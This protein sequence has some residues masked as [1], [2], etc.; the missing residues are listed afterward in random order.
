M[1]WLSAE[2]LLAVLGVLATVGVLAY[3]RLIPG[4]KRIGYRVQ[5]D[6]P[7]GGDAHNGQPDVRLGLFGEAPEMSDASL[8][9]LRIE[10][11]GLRGISADDYTWRELT[12]LTV[13]FTERTVT[14]VAVTEPSHSHLIQHFTRYL[15]LR[16]DGNVISVPKVPLNKGEHFK[17]LVLLTGSGVGGAVTVSGGLKDGAVKRNRK[18]PRPSNRVLG[19]VTFLAALLLL[20]PLVFTLGKSSPAPLGCAQG[21]L[22][23]TGS[24]AFGPALRDAGRAYEKEC[25]GAKIIVQATGSM[26]GIRALEAA[27]DA[28]GKGAGKGAGKR[29]GKGAPAHLALS[30]GPKPAHYKQLRGAQVAVSVFTLVVNDDA[31]VRDLSLREVRDIYR[32]TIRNWKEVGGR[33]LPVRLVSRGADSGT[34]D[35]FQRRVL[36]GGEQAYSS[37][38]CVTRD[39]PR[40]P[41]V[42]CELDS[43]EE[44]LKTIGKTPGAVGYSELRAASGHR[45]LH[46]LKL[47]GRAASADA[48]ADGQV[49]EDLLT[50][51][52]P[53]R[54]IEYAYTYGQ[55]SAGSI[56]AGFLDYLVTGS[57]RHAVRGQGHLP[58]A[59]PP[60]EQLCGSL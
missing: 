14:G 17:L 20:E 15:G 58:C 60:N 11:D 43:T 3:E 22:T 25:P 5:M 59:S 51:A 30:D 6:T 45:G 36:G 47:N 1:E 52:Y 54:E 13:T 55:P 19:L 35:V 29:A 16:H 56:T 21:E 9:L 31:R 24:T 27:G 37:R 28:A 44:V 40:A 10:N 50:G 57:G 2:S 53:Y 46:T 39:D 49:A 32:G 18:Q 42:R 8:V 48:T 4:L 23:V 41:V 26:A 38:D 34:R 12:G 7:I 33:D